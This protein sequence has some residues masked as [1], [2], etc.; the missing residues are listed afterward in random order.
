MRRI[1]RQMLA[2][3]AGVFVVVSAAVQSQQPAATPTPLPSPVPREPSWAFQVQGGSLPAEDPSPKSVPG[4][5]RQYTPA[6][7]DDLR[8]PPDWFPN[9]HPP[10]AARVVKGEGNLMAC[11]SCHLMNG[12]GHPESATTSGF[13]VD[14]FVQQMN[15]FR[16]GARKDFANRMDLIAKAMTDQEIREVAQYFAS[17]KPRQFTTVR[18][19]ATV[20]RTFV[21]Q[22]R[23]R[24]VDPKG[25]TEPIG[26]RIITLP[27]DQERARRRD[28]NSG[29]IAY[30]PPGSIA[31]GRAL[32]QGGSRTVQCSICHGEGL[33]G[34]GN[35]PRIAGLHPIYI[36]RQLIHFKEGTRNGVDAALMK[37]T[38]AGLTD[39]DI[40]ALSAYVG[41]LARP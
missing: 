38:T 14:Y 11:G 6:Q 36:A 21:G 7:I 25:G 2:L 28:P 30:V 1:M 10:A 26:K 31:R 34:L 20:P 37:K 40:I 41:S 29:F 12:E 22:G 9:D 5:T 18:E 27:E 13:T 4:S 3:L 35:V 23:M 33:R 15:D 19:A 39:D 32:A 24:F 17:I 8:N 16:S